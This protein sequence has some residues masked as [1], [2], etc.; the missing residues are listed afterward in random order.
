MR[1]FSTVLTALAIA[2]VVALGAGFVEFVAVSH[3]S[4]TVPP[5]AD[6]IVALT[7]GAERVE[8]GL[9]LLSAGRARLLLVS[10]VSHSA[11][12]AEL[13]HRVGLED[14][15]IAAR[16]TLGRVA[17]TTLGNAEETSDWVQ[18][19]GIH[20]LIVVTAGFHMPR[21]LLELHRA[22][23]DVV[24]YAVPVQPQG[25]GHLHSFRLLA[26]EYVKLLAAWAGVSR[27]IRQPVSEVWRHPVDKSV[28]G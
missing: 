21:A 8:T 2:I 12:L 22:M 14:G 18:R 28:N 5:D 19:H 27:V 15:P 17:T 11:A 10:G 20:S 7:G 4:A 26:A 23:P 25:I 9:R 13:L 24:L 1:R 3:R 6:G 16:V